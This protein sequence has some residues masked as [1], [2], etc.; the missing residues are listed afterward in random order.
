MPIAVKSD[1]MGRAS[2]VRIVPPSLSE[3]ASAKVCFRKRHLPMTLKSFRLKLSHQRAIPLKPS[4]STTSAV[5][6]MSG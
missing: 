4:Q 3:R 2:T 5:R 6:M 1:C